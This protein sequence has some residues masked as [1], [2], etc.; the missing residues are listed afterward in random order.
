MWRLGWD[1]DG[2]PGVARWPG[3]YDEPEAFEAAEAAVASIVGARGTLVTGADARAMHEGWM[4]DR[5]K[6]SVALAKAL[7]DA[8]LE[9]PATHGAAVK[10]QRRLYAGGM[11]AAR[12]R[13]DGSAFWGAR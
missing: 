12:G 9:V 3:D 4:R 5:R 10:L 6:P 13:A 8:G 1:P 7:T 2:T 11:A